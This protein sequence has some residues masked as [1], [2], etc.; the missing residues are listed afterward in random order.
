MCLCLFGPSSPRRASR[1]VHGTKSIVLTVIDLH[2]HLLP[3][4]DDGPADDEEMV[5]LA[6]AAVQGGTQVIV[7]TPHLDHRWGVEISDVLRGLPA[8]RDALAAAGVELEVVAGAE[9][10]LQRFIELSERDLDAVRLGAGPYLLVESPHEVA[11]GNFTSYLHRLR[12]RGYELVLAHPERCPT[13]HSRPALLAELVQDGVLTSITAGSLG[14]R[15]GREVQE[16]SLSLFAQGLVHGV[17]SDAHGVDRRGPEMSGHLAV[18]EQ[19]LPGISVHARWLT[20]DAPAAILA[21]D[22][23]PE[24]PPLPRRRRRHRHRH[25]GFFSKLA[26]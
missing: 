4:I 2:F 16:L 9:I 7:A 24:R 17:A 1:F 3:G 22:P 21:G 19:A 13:F 6:R 25:P 5:A 8:A 26:S 18:A 15:F 20:H 23:L 11:A 14:G 10:S 12:N